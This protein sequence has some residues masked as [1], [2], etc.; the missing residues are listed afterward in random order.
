VDVA[1]REK[2]HACM[3]VKE[4]SGR[5]EEKDAQPHVGG[6]RGVF[7]KLVEPHLVTHDNETQS[8]S[9]GQEPTRAEWPSQ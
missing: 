3:A 7:S 4:E 9:P 6:N 1:R 2:E 8:Q 5:D